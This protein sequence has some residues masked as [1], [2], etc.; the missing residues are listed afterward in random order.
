MIK[1][2]IS[3][4]NEM[5]KIDKIGNKLFIKGKLL[6][7]IQYRTLDKNT[8]LYREE[9][10]NF[11]FPKNFT[12]VWFLDD[13]NYKKYFISGDENLV[14]FPSFRSLGNF[15][16]LPISDLW[17]KNT[18]IQKH[19]IGAIRAISNDEL[20]YIDMMSVRPGYKRNGINYHMI[21]T[22]IKM[23]PKAKLKFSKPT[24]EGKFFIE[25]YFPNAEIEI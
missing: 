3:F 2:F 21:K 20:I 14:Y 7:D 22:L 13:D 5:A 1:N 17:K 4:I 6:K 19:I 9:K 11:L 8:L 23:F 25:K 15:N 12:M 16:S 10:G 18:P 24:D